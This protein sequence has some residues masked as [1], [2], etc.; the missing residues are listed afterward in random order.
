M[1][2]ENPGTVQRK[3][4]GGGGPPAGQELPARKTSG[5]ESGYPTVMELTPQGPTLHRR[6]MPQ[7]PHR[8][9]S[10]CPVPWNR[11][12]PRDFRDPPGPLSSP[13][14]GRFATTTHTSVHGRPLHPDR[15]P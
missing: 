2:K 7:A 5:Q 3:G 4:R 12:S 14:H 6:H 13:S 15:I 10:C 9:G 11:A 8:P 1:S